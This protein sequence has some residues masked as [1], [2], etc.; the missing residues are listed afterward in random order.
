MINV[1]H[2]NASNIYCDGCGAEL[3]NL[4]DYYWCEECENC[5]VCNKSVFG[6]LPDGLDLSDPNL[7]IEVIDILPEDAYAYC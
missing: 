3:F 7:E 5:G 4:G 1:E 2:S 6:R